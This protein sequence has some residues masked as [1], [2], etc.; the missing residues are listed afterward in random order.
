MSESPEEMIAE[1]IAVGDA[2]GTGSRERARLLLADAAVLSQANAE[3]PG[4]GAVHEVGVGTGRHL[5]WATGNRLGPNDAVFANA[6]AIH[7][8]F[9][10]DTDMSTWSHPGSFVVPAAVAAATE[11]GASFARLLDAIV[12]GYSATRWL[13]ADGIVAA[14]LKARGFRPSPIFA[15]LGAAIAAS[16]ALGLDR[17]AAAHAVNAAA[18]IG[19]GTLHSVGNGGDDWRLHNA[20]GARDGFGLALAAQRG[21]RS[22]ADALTAENGFLRTVTGSADIPA[23]WRTAPTGEL[24][25]RVWHKALPVLGDVMSA[26]LAAR[27]IGRRLEGLRVDGVTVQMNAKYAL[28][29]GTQQRPPYASATAAQA[30]VRFVVAQLLVR[31][32]LRYTD[33]VHHDDP[34]VLRVADQIDV[35]PVEGMPYED[36]IVEVRAGGRAEHFQAADLPPTLFWRDRPEQYDRAEHILGARGVAISR[37]ILDADESD[38]AETVLDRA[39]VSSSNA[40][41]EHH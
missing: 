2:T 4:F 31:G 6:C 17:V 36:A 29:P 18:L 37:S 16:R 12:V 26:A 14:A 21:M 27:E 38:S 40:P 22:A 28:F 19:R 41:K 20:G 35:V 10:D 30:S 39:L 3:V 15:P 24:I 7:A 8:R 32:D 5:S 11:S 25:E 23:V 13:G 33:L 9:Q 1:F 34:E